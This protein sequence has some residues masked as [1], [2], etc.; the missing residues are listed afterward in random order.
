MTKFVREP[1]EILKKYRNT[2]PGLL[3]TVRG[4]C[5]TILLAI[6]FIYFVIL[7]FFVATDQPVLSKVLVPKPYIL[8]PGKRNHVTNIRVLNYN[9]FFLPIFILF[10]FWSHN[11][12]VKISS[13]YEFSITCEFNYLGKCKIYSFFHPFFDNIF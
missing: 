3:V 9:R 7:V 6:L 2:E 11:L 10:F 12:V 1:R 5:L 13:K 4:L 8:A